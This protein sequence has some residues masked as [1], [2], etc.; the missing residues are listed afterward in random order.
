M[1]NILN[2]FLLLS[3]FWTITSCEVGPK[4]EDILEPKNEPY[5]SLDLL[6]Q[7]VVPSKTKPSR[8]TKFQLDSFL[9]HQ[10]KY[11]DSQGLELFDVYLNESLDTTSITIFVYSNNLLI[12]TNSYPKDVSGHRLG[13]IFKYLY[14]SD[15][16]LHQIIR[17][18]KIHLQY[19]YNDKGLVSEI[20][21]GPVPESGEGYFF[22][23]DENGRITRQIWGISDQTVSPIRDWHYI[24]DESGKL[25]SKSIPVFPNGNLL[26]MFVYSYD[27]QDRMILEEE[28][29]PEYGFSS[30]FKTFYSYSTVN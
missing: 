4:E 15:R 27:E 22:Y 28:L 21:F 14:N 5:Y 19:S 18:G 25:I 16:K 23:Y 26:P 29:Y 11:Y 8:I 30:Y 3:V 17:E 2:Y 20:I 6:I 12:E 1:K 13:T 24:Y 9:Y 7:K 10:D